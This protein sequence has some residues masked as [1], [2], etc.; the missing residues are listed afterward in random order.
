MAWDMWP[1]NSTKLCHVL[2][3]FFLTGWKATGTPKVCLLAIVKYALVTMSV[4][5]SMEDAA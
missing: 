4:F 3:A 5:P 1:F 2:S